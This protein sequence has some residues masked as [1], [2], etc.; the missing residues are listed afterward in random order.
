MTS[1]IGPSNTR[2]IIKDS[3]ICISSN[4]KIICYY[5]PVILSCHLWRL[6]WAFSVQENK[7]TLKMETLQRSVWEHF[8]LPGHSLIDLKVAILQ[9]KVF[10]GLHHWEAAELKSRGSLDSLRPGLSRDWGMLSSLE[11]AITLP[12][13]LMYTIQIFSYWEWPHPLL[14]PCFLS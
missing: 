12:M 6:N 7:W 3:F 5:A 8:C 1:V 2:N 10:K 13:R 9:W 14:T 4:E 11:K